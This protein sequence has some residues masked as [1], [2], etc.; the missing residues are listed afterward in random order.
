MFGRYAKNL[1]NFGFKNSESED[2]KINIQIKSELWGV[3][4]KQLEKIIV[5]YRLLICTK[6]KG[7]DN[8]SDRE[9]G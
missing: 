3:I 7:F 9:K 6:M 4:Y 1:E 5:L 8:I 2:F